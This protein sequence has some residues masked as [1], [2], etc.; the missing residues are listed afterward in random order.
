MT[1]T[2]TT[3]DLLTGRKF[4]DKGLIVGFKNGRQQFTGTT[5]DQFDADLKLTLPTTSATYL[6]EANYGTSGN[7]AADITLAWDVTGG[8][9]AVRCTQAM[10]LGGTT[11]SETAIISREQ[12]V[13]GWGAGTSTTPAPCAVREKLIVTTGS[14]PSV[15][16][17]VW[18][19]NVSNANP[20]SVHD[21]SWVVARRLT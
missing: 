6:V 9:T 18:H 14:E 5:S 21:Y 1:L 19:Q 10:A 16:T 7:T 4:Q 8:A 12:S 20:T 3:S 15:L 17:L 2:W 11:S 13:E